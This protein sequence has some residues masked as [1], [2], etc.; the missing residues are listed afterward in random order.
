MGIIKGMF[1]RGDT[2]KTTQKEDAGI[3]VDDWGEGVLICTHFKTLPYLKTVFDKIPPLIYGRETQSKELH[4]AR[5]AKRQR[6][7]Q[8]R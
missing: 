4:E 7:K 5:I 1:E 6:Q 8:H 2:G 3:L